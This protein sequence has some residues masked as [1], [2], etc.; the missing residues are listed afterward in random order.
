AKIF[1]RNMPYGTVM[2]H[3]TMFVGF[4]SE[5]SRLSEMLR[6]MAGLVDG[7]R[8]S[9]TRYT[10]PSPVRTTSFPRRRACGGGSAPLR[11]DV[12]SASD[13]EARILQIEIAGEAVHHVVVDDSV[14]A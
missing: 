3:G 14:M 11:P 4:S 9:L 1:R 13:V 8:D 5:Q 6:S 12:R 10:R 7:V 2:A